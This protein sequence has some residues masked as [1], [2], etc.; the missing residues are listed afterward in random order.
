[1]ISSSP[2]LPSTTTTHDHR[3]SPGWSPEHGR[4]TVSRMYFPDQ[5]PDVARLFKR[6]RITGKVPAGKKPSLTN[7][8]AMEKVDPSR[9]F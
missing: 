5:D 7:A 6:C 1:M 8:K 3:T 4:N 2:P 9:I